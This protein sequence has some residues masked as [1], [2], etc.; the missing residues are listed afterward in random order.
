MKE[1]LKKLLEVKLYE[2]IDIYDLNQLKKFTNYIIKNEDENG[3]QVIF[4]PINSPNKY[5]LEISNTFNQYTIMFGL[6][7]KDKVLTK[8]DVKDNFVLNVLSTVFTLIR[9]YID[10]YKIKSINFTADKKLRSPL[11]SLYLK[12]H[13]S[14][15]KIKKSDFSG[16]DSYILTK[17]ER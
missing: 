10:K 5:E 15:F 13:F 4:S 2:S 7:D 11:Y 1:K 6:I 16:A 14:D 8:V 9:Y 3:F 17:N 12:K